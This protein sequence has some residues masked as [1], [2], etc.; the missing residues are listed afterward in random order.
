M[1]LGRPALALYYAGW[2]RYVLRGRTHALLFAPL[3]G[4]PLVLSVAPVVYFGA[5]ALLL[6]SRPLAVAPALLAAGHLGVSA[7]EHRRVTRGLNS[8]A[9]EESE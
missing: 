2:V 8:H 7:W 9:P 5:A 1:P 3:C 4:I 6:R